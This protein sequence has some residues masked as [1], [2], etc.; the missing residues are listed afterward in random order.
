MGDKPI[1]VQEIF[2]LSDVEGGINPQ[3]VNFKSVTLESDKFLCVRDVTGDQNSI[4]IVELGNRSNQRHRITADSAIMNPVSKVLALKAG[5]TLQIFNLDMKAK[6]KAFTMTENVLFWRWISAQTIALVTPTAIF[7]WSMDGTADP[8]K[9]FDRKPELGEGFQILSYKTDSTLTWLALVGVAKQ[10]DGSLKGSLQLHSV[11]KNASR[12]IEGHAAC[13]LEFAPP[14]SPQCTLL[15]VAHNSPQGGKLFIM[16]VPTPHKPE[17]TYERKIQNISFTA[18]TDFPVA[19]QGSVKHGILYLITRSGLLYLFDAVTSTL[20]LS[21]QITSDPIFVTTPE[22]RTQGLLGV[23]TRGQVLAI[24]VNEQNLVKFVQT[25][26]NNTDIAMR[27]AATAGTRGGMSDELFVHKFNQ[28]LAEMNINEAVKLVTEAPEGLLRTRET[29]QRLAALPQLAGQ[30]A[31]LSVY[32]KFLLERGKLNSFEAVE[33]ARV[34]LQKQGG[35]GYLKKLIEEEKLDESEELGDLLAPHD[36]DLALRIYFK[37]NAHMKVL[38]VLLQRGEYQKVTAY[39]QKRGVTPEWQQLLIS[40]L[41]VNPDSA[42]QFAVSL[43]H[44][45]PPA[46]EPNLVIDLFVQRNLI[47]QVTAYLLDVLKDDK[48]EEANLQTRLLEINL[49]YSPPQV[50]DQILGQNICTHYDALKVARLCEKAQLYQRALEN[51]AKV[52]RTNPDVSTSMDI[53]RVVINT[54]AINPDWLVEF[55]GNLSR[56]DSIE[57]LRELLTNNQRQNFKVCVQVATKYSEELSAENLIDLFLSFKSYEALYYYLGSIVNFSKEPEVHFRYIEAA[58][59]VGQYSEVERITRESKVYEPERT[60]NFLKEVKLQDLWPLINVCDQHNY[61]EELVKYLFDT[62][63]LKYVDMYIQKRS[64]QKTPLVVGGLLDCDC[65]EDYVKNLILSVG[66]MCP[67]EPLVTEV[68]KR[69]RLKLLQGWLEARAHEGQTD[70]V[71][72]NA[73]G[74]IYIDSNQGAEEFLKRNEHYD[75]KILGKYCENRDPTLAFIAYQRGQCDFELVEI[76][77]KNGMFKQQA[78]Y[79]VKRQNPELWAHVLEDSTHRKKLVDQVVQTALPEVTVPEEVST[80]VKAF[81]TANLPH[82]LTELLEKIVL[83]GSSEFKNN[84]YLQNL[85]ILTAIKADKTRVMDYVNRLDNYDAPEIAGIAESAEL[86]EEAFVVY[87]K[88]D[89]TQAIRVLID[90]IKSVERATEFAEKVQ[91]AAVWSVLANAQ[92]RMDLVP[93]AIDAFIRARDATKFQDVI[94]ISEASGHFNELVKYLHMARQESKTKEASIDTALVYALAKTD[95]RAELEEFIATP[96]V[97]Q[98]QYIADRCFNETLYESAKI[99]YTNI[100]NYARLAI[101]L[102]RLGNFYA[103]VDAAQK[104]NSTKTWKEVNASCVDAKEFKLAQ[105]CALQIVVHADELEDLIQYYERGGY[106][107]ELITLMKAGLGLDRAH[108][109]MFTGLGVLYAK[110][111]PEKLMEHIKLYHKRVNYHRLIRICEQYYHWAEARFLY[112][113]NDEFDNAA[114]LMMQHPAVAWEHEVFKET[115]AKAS[116]MEL[117]IQAIHFYINL[118]PTR[119]CDLLGT[120]GAKIDHERIVQEVR[121]DGRLPL[122][123]PWIETVQGGNLRGVN[124]ALNELLVE[125]EDY[126][127]LRI[128]IDQ[129]DNFDQIGLADSLKKHELLE[130][131]RIAAYL[132]KRNKRWKQSV[133]LSK[134]DK[135]YKDAMETT[136]ESEDKDLA[137]ELLR[138]FVDSNQHE[139][140]S[141]CLYTCYELMR[142][143]VALE[144]AWRNKTLD[145]AMPYLIQMVK[146]YHE[147]MEDL[148]HKVEALEKAK[149]EASTAPPPMN[150]LPPGIGGFLPPPPG[151]GGFMQPPMHPPMPG[152]R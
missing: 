127:A 45:E 17:A 11:E 42:V 68:E 41:N 35:S 62:N 31:P 139:C 92:L 148:V 121:K 14:G 55:F 29:I 12:V 100:N 76:T 22:E 80:T 150:A 138:F 126:E 90:C 87:K 25:S 96:N 74:K 61:V 37:G 20:L 98:I 24:S 123:K 34:V 131:R 15:C 88:F 40:S 118:H 146:E 102:V 128:S 63:N 60:K 147:K 26:L 36:S 43:N 85:L 47:K 9:M 115:M 19:L 141:A 73:L 89:N 21:E 133:E 54:H 120:I 84:R 145:F 79:L 4:V 106:F 38:Q 124:T 51:Y 136:A 81:M 117:G 122:I 5:T 101:C 59:R 27:L 58:T 99:L 10:A 78:R 2:K 8:Q 33:L 71:L 143:D 69:N 18:P 50:A 142:P 103:A 151:A 144:L 95:R 140:Y 135:M 39:C 66:P 56:E 94:Q 77:T 65:S 52:T 152:W 113:H 134:A 67:V 64:P 32:F 105:I 93:D 1:S 13:F 70:P 82:E 132:Y 119:L 75:S 48:P 125:E 110:Y 107:E 57:C 83:H 3:S 46:L 137:E 72:H 44:M 114:K 111:R 91:E 7:H 30:T 116:S 53:R 97:A 129:F 86:F 108:M 6:M 104:A 28:L 112:T 16:E 109:G 49:M 130:F 149:H 23:N